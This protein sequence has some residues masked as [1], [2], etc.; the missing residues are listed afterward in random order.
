MGL[1]LLQG[2]GDRDLVNCFYDGAKVDS[3]NVVIF[4]VRDLDFKER[5]IIEQV[6]VKVVWYDEIIQKGLD[7]ALEEVKDYLRIENLHV[8]F[9]LDAINP[10]Y[11]PGVSVPVRNGFATEDIFQVFKFLFKTYFVT[12]IDIVEYNPVNDKNDKTL[13]FVNELTNYVVNPD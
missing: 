5:E 3:K 10:E 8:S 2:I 9:D 12:S 11:A 4:G 6:G 13:N 1:A 7:Q